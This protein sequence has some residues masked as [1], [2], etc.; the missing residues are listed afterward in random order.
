MTA[1]SVDAELV[2]HA[3]QRGQATN[4]R[5][6][7]EIGVERKNPCRRD[8]D[9]QAHG[10]VALGAAHVD[11]RVV[12]VPDD[13]LDDRMEFGL[14]RTE[15]LGGDGAPDRFVKV[16]ETPEGT[17][18][19]ADGRAAWKQFFPEIRLVPGK[20]AAEIAAVTDRPDTIK[21]SRCPSLKL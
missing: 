17:G 19:D 6:G 4:L 11:D 20:R 5:A 9:R 12:G 16:T 18:L 13:L 7:N 10:V 15:P 3:V 2:R 14:V 8:D 1:K 21:D